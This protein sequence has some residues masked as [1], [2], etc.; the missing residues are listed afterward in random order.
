MEE[1]EKRELAKKIFYN[2]KI[3][4]LIKNSSWRGFK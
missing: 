3:E 2:R 4:H 1:I